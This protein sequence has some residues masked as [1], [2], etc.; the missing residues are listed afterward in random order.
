MILIHPAA[1]AEARAACLRYA[2]RDPAVARRFIA[3]YDRAVERIREHPDRWP[4]YPH[5]AGEF[6]WCRFRRFP[7]AIIYEVFP[8]I[9]HVL[10]VA[11]DRRRPGYWAGRK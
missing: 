6:R 10:A 9:T 8:T 11:A 5:L 4:M 1:A 7:Y 3:E 2:E